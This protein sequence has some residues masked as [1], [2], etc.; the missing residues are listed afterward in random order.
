[1][2]A[3]RRCH[4]GPV[5]ARLCFPTTAIPGLHVF[6]T[7][8]AR[9]P[10]PPQLRKTRPVGAVEIVFIDQ[11]RN[12]PEMNAVQLPATQKLIDDGVTANTVL[13]VA[14]GKSID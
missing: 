8:A 9:P 13:S 12:D 7:V 3:R 10:R 6:Q 5:S 11:I 4:H 2:I 14:H 1:M